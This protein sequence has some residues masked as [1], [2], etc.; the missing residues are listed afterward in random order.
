MK[1]KWTARIE[2]HDATC[3][4]EQSDIVASYEATRQAA[5]DAMAANISVV[6]GK[7]ANASKAA[8]AAMAKWDNAHGQRIADLKVDLGRL[9]VHRASMNGTFTDAVRD[10]KVAAEA[11]RA[12][13]EVAKKTFAS[14]V[15]AEQA[16]VDELMSEDTLLLNETLTVADKILKE[17]SMICEATHDEVVAIVNADPY[18]KVAPEIKALNDCRIKSVGKP[19]VTSSPAISLLEVGTGCAMELMALQAAHAAAVPEAPKSSWPAVSMLRGKNATKRDVVAEAAKKAFDQVVDKA[20][21]AVPTPEAVPTPKEEKFQGIISDKQGNTLPIPIATMEAKL[22][23]RKDEAAEAF[24]KCTGVLQ[25]RFSFS[26]RGERY[27]RDWGWGGGGPVPIF[28]GERH[29]QPLS[30]L[31]DAYC[32]V[33]VHLCCRA[34]TC[35]VH[36]ST[37]CSLA[38]P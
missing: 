3:K 8:A 30:E 24:G 10:N 20:V 35:V 4:E 29:P 18:Y 38:P 5:E 26:K 13:T 22:Q 19:L 1:D 16:N 25:V 23:G 17:G 34:L 21:G 32:P 2:K 12:Q 6:A 9:E 31:M 15:A 27:T 11:E 37:Y 14:R 36:P 28:G 33:S 7:W